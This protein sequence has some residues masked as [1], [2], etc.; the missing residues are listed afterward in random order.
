MLEWLRYR[1]HAAKRRV[2]HWAVRA[3]VDE[4]EAFH[5]TAFDTAPAECA[6]PLA[7]AGHQPI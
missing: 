5:R 7:Q 1:L 2:A 4:M 3:E 6:E